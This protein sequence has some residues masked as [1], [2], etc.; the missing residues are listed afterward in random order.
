MIQVSNYWAGLWAERKEIYGVNDDNG[1][2]IGFLIITCCIFA[3]LILRA[4]FFGKFASRSSYQLFK[5]MIKNVLRRPMSFFDTTPNG[6]I[7]NRCN[8]DVYQ[9]DFVVP[10]SISFFLE[11]FAIFAVAVII[12]IAALP[13]LAV[14]VVVFGILLFF[15]MRKYMRTAV[16]LRR[17]TQLAVSPLL[18]KVSEVIGGVI[19][20]RAYDKIEWM[21]YKYNKALELY[22]S[23]QLH[24]RLSSVWINFRLELMVAILAASTPFLI[25]LIK[26]QDWNI[27]SNRGNNAIYGTVLT[28]I[29]LLG[30]QMAFFIFSFSETAKG[31]NS[32]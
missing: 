26:T 23:C 25:A 18:N 24:E 21:K 7:M 28:N 16:E 8:D 17:L 15:A 6:V 2:G 30:N 20:I 3:T 11:S 31:M 27:G 13:V 5:N 4:F 32:V 19:S 10:S 22:T 29:F 9:V 1:Y 12:V 14:V